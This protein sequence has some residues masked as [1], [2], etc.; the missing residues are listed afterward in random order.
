M[1]FGRAQVNVGMVVTDDDD[2][3]LGHVRSVDD[4]TFTVDRPG[5]DV[6]LPYDCVQAIVGDRVVL[7]L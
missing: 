5:G 3:R 1:T 6:R 2:V 7:T 4:T